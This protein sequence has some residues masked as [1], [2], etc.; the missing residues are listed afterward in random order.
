MVLQKKTTSLSLDDVFGTYSTDD[1]STK[2]SRGSIVPSLYKE[3]DEKDGNDKKA[4][5]KIDESQKSKNENEKMESTRRLSLK[6]ERRKE[7][8]EETDDGESDGERKKV[9]LY[10]ALISLHI[11]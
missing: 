8:V 11:F 1:E 3:K 5:I 7:K 6:K 2:H 10:R 9:L 4:S